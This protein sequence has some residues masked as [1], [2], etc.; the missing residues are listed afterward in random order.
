MYYLGELKVCNVNIIF[1]ELVYSVTIFLNEKPY[2]QRE[3]RGVTEISLNINHS[4]NF[5]IDKKPESVTFSTRKKYS[6]CASLPEREKNI[7]HKPIKLKYNPDLKHSPAR[8]DVNTGEIQY[9]DYYLTL[10]ILWQEFILLHE[11]GHHFYKTEEYCDLYAL[12]NYI[13]N[14]GNPS[15]AFY[16]LAKVF[17]RPEFQKSR[18]SNIYSKIKT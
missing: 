10:P 9:G 13:E 1:P 5:Y 6:H 11:I 15:Q 18:I 3:F 12:K 17:K 7:P 8:I 2:Y 4:G 16:S 14:Y